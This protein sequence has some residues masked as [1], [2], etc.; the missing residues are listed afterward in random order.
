MKPLSITFLSLLACLAIV[1]GL[2]VAQTNF[3]HYR[4]VNRH[5]G[6]GRYEPVYYGHYR[7]YRFNNRN[8]RSSW[9]NSRPVY[10]DPR[11]SRYARPGPNVPVPMV[12]PTPATMTNA[13]L[14]SLNA[15]TTPVP[16][17]SEAIVST[18]PILNSTRSLD[19]VNLTT[20]APLSLSTAVLP[21]SPI[22][23]GSP[24]TA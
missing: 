9:S 16:I 14:T 6:N 17:A 19:S 24:S 12:R 2:C 22:N 15:T 18:T 7:P 4:P 20:E 1:A 21:S 23:R 5:R 11:T 8:G 3:I 10:V 13:T